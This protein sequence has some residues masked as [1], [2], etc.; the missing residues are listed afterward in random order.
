MQQT[1]LKDH[2][3]PAVVQTFLREQL[4]LTRLV[5]AHQK[6]TG[7]GDGAELEDEGNDSETSAVS[8]QPSE[9]EEEDDPKTFR[10]SFRGS[11]VSMFTIVK[12]AGD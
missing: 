9:D 2:V 4:S 7:G 6:H 1:G 10:V 3:L 11:S 12:E 8:W 5:I